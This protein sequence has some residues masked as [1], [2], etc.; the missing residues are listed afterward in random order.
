MLVPPPGLL[1]LPDAS[2]STSM[3]SGEERGI[4][5]NGE[6]VIVFSVAPRSRGLKVGTV[7]LGGG[8]YKMVYSPRDNK[9]RVFSLDLSV[10]ARVRGLREWVM[11]GPWRSITPGTVRI[12]ARTERAEA[13]VVAVHAAISLSPLPFDPVGV[14]KRTRPAEAVMRDV[15]E[16]SLYHS[17]G[18]ISAMEGSEVRVKINEGMGDMVALGLLDGDSLS[19]VKAIRNSTL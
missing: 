12:E 11:R 6:Q 7:V 13:M 8:V 9:A 16:S 10:R 15:L 14:G 5:V 17:T 3:A 4:D 2:T 19:L 1:S 18:L